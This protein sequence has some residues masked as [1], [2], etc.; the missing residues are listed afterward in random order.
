MLATVCTL[1]SGSSGNSLYIGL[2][3]THVLVDLGIG[4]RSLRRA[5]GEVDVKPEWLSAVVLTH[6]HSD[7]I[8]GLAGFSSSWPHVPILASPGTARALARSALG[9]LARPDLKPGVETPLGAL[10]IT[11]VAVSHDAAQPCGFRVRCG[12]LHLAVFTDLGVAPVQIAQAMA[13]CRL[14]VLEANHDDD[15]LWMGPYPMHLKRRIAS[16]RGH[17]SNLQ[18][19][20]LLS[21]VA[22]PGLE[23]VILAHLSAE[24]NEPERAVDAARRAVADRGPIGLTAA[25]RNRPGTPIRLV[26][27]PGRESDDRPA[28]PSAPRQLGLFG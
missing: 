4:P 16:P 11:P 8:H 20:S 2:D 26:L 13:G 15:M 6:E 14:L 12:S 18:S 3:D 1:A 27:E 21:A 9:P 5:L 17:L 10:C 7:H 28:A 23:H 22:G 25:P 24:N 19:A